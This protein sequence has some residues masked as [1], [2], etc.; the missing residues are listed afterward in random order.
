MAADIVAA[1]RGF[2]AAAWRIQRFF[3]IPRRQYARPHLTESVPQRE[4]DAVSPLEGPIRLGSDAHK[5]LFCRTFCFDT[6]NPYKPA[7]LDW[8]KLDSQTARFSW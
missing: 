5:T 3:W 6:F 1:C 8:P 2:F 7:V 4:F